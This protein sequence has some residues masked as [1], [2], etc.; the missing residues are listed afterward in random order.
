M[1]ES[2]KELRERSISGPMTKGKCLIIFMFEAHTLVWW[3][4]L[5]TPWIPSLQP[6]LRNLHF[7]FK[8]LAISSVNS[9]AVP[10]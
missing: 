10:A 8:R 6:N 9:N 2:Y 7:N 4:V 1:G 5:E 3:P